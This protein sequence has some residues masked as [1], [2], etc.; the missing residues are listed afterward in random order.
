MKMED[1]RDWESGWNAGDMMFTKG[2]VGGKQ[3]GKKI[4]GR[5][6]TKLNKNTNCHLQ[7]SNLHPPKETA[8]KR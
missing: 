6:K 4:E 1:V 5:K 3:I 7:D 8:R 2:G